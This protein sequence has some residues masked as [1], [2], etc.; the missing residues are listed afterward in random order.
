MRTSE[1]L[2]SARETVADFFG[3][4]PENVVFTLNCTYALNMAIQGIMNGGGHMII[5]SI[6]HNSVARPAAKLAA[7]KK[8]SLSIA[9]SL[10]RKTKNPRKFQKSYP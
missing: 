3:A 9:K 1:A 4:Q 8:I 6:E 5:S 10:P 7:D 2:Y